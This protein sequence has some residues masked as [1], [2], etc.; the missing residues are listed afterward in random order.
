MNI[1]WNK[2]IPHIVAIVVFFAIAMT[3]FSPA[4]GD[5]SIRS[6]DIKMHKGMSKEVYDHR[7]E[8]DEEPLWTNAMF[9]GMP[10]TQISVRYSSNLIAQ[11]HNAWSGLTP[12]PI[13]VLLLYFIGF[14]ILLLTLKVDP[15]LA[16]AASVAYGMSAY[17]FI[18]MGAGHNSKAAAV[19]YMAP[20]LA[21]F[22]LAFRGKVLLGTAMLTLFM[23]LQI[24]AN[25]PQISYYFF[26]LLFFIYCYEASKLLKGGETMS[27]LKRTGLLAVGV[28]LAVSTNVP[29]LYS[30]YEYSPHTQRGGSE[31]TVLAADGS[32]QEK[33]M[34]KDY[35]LQWSYGKDETWNFFIPNAKGGSSTPI[36]AN[37]DLKNNRDFAEL[38]EFVN[39]N[40]QFYANRTSDVL[41]EYFGNQYSTSG[42]V[43]I[44]AV[45]CLLF[46][47]AMVFWRNKLKWPLF[48]MTVLAIM[49]A[50]GRNLEWLTDIFW[51]YAPM[52]NKFR[53][54]TNILVIVELTLP[55]IGFLWLADVLKNKDKYQEDFKLPFTD[56]T[57]PTKK[58][59]LGVSGFAVALTLLFAAAPGAFFDL[60][61]D[62]EAQMFTPEYMTQQFTALAT[63]KPN[64]V[65]PP[66]WTGTPQQ[67]A[68]AVANSYTPKLGLAQAQLTEYRVGLVR[69]DALRSLLF[70]ALTVALLYVFLYAG[71][72]KPMY[73][74]LALAGLILADL[75]PV[76]LRYFNNE[77][78]DRKNY[79]M[80]VD[81]EEKLIPFSPTYADNAILTNEA[82]KNPQIGLAIQ[83]HLSKRKDELGHRLTPREANSATFAKLNMLTNYRVFLLSGGYSQE[84]SISY[85]H[86]SLGGY[87]AAKIQR[88]QDLI[89]R[90]MQGQ[91]QLASNPNTLANAKILNMLNTRYIVTNP[92]GTG[93]FID[94]SNPATLSPENQQ[95]APGWYNTSALGNAWFVD[96][97]KAHN[98]PDEEFA[99]LDQLDVANKAIADV[100]YEVNK[101]IDKQYTKGAAASIQ[102]TNYK[103]NEITYA[104]SG[105]EG[106]EHFV[107]FSEIYYPLG[108]TA[109]VDGKPV[110]VK[111]VNYTLRGVE[112]PAGTKEIQL[113]YELKSFGSLSMVALSTSGIIIL[114][115]IGLGYMSLV[116]QRDF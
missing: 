113:K 54:V 105:A 107:V 24:N 77:K 81:I 15:W 88:Y 108:W 3:Y 16:L 116:K 35:A 91:M 47:L 62:G 73:F 32:Q 102:M 103:A 52:Y 49:L 69:S 95:T 72:I 22:L 39:L 90:K 109:Y 23:S 76:A 44:G 96:E 94:M 26:M 38:N 114:L 21:G 29:N 71:S 1:N 7:E 17:F 115:V 59:F 60:E 66:D 93:Q 67:Y 18:I 42:P 20:T 68:A 57:I 19:A 104:V 65:L 2:S 53:A 14:Y 31:L 11:I 87:H 63:S 78:S 51:D 9:G 83:Q 64:E 6:H 100:K 41:T 40:Y 89:E 5:Y 79:D 10:A 110:D 106:G 74:S 61:R 99:A 97:V 98:S 37:E 56:K 36:L 30:T 55:V 4:L 8:Y 50:W 46:F 101:G 12:H 58:L 84:T 13:S 75:T 92:N 25:H 111:R 28:L 112:V 85:F 48:A 45:V 43:Y 70:V 34:T 80:W 86:K 82:Q 33:G 27:L